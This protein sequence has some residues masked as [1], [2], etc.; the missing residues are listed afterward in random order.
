VRSK[1]CTQITPTQ[2]QNRNAA[3][4]C[5]QS[6]QKLTNLLS[7]WATWHA[8]RFDVAGYIAPELCS[9]SIGY[10]PSEMHLGPTAGMVVEDRPIAPTDGPAF[11]NVLYEKAGDV[12]A[13]DRFSELLVRRNSGM[14]TAADATRTALERAVSASGGVEA[15]EAGAAVR[16]AKRV[17]GGSRCFNCGS[18]GH[19]LRE[20]WKEHNMDAIDAARRSVHCNKAA[21]RGLHA[22]HAVC[23]VNA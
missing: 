6:L 12:P 14:V 22:S 11:S 19:G 16:P 20:C 15:G 18:Y 9:G 17:R 8:A 5:R 10:R 3:V 4:P 21:G 7:D 2:F 13:Y 23:N 1:H